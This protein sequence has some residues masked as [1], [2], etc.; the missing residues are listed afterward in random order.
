MCLVLNNNHSLIRHKLSNLVYYNVLCV[1][2][3]RVEKLGTAILPL[4]HHFVFSSP[5]QRGI[6]T[7]V[8]TLSPSFLLIEHLL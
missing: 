6:S 2:Y 1:I 7:I 8:I 3:C 4:Q 5:L